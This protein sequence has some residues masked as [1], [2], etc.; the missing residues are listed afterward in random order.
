MKFRIVGIIRIIVSGIIVPSCWTVL[1]AQQVSVSDVK[2]LTATAN[3]PSSLFT[4]DDFGKIE[5]KIFTNDQRPAAMV[6]VFIRETGK[7][8]ITNDN[9]SFTVGRLKPGRYTLEV[10]LVGYETLV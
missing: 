10:S 9:G 7:S 3:N 1:S 5:G 8:Y 2:Q 6:T 4:E